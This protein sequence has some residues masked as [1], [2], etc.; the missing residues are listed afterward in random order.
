VVN[1]THILRQASR[2]L[3]VRPRRPRPT[4]NDYVLIFALAPRDK[5]APGED[6]FF[7]QSQVERF[8]PKG[9]YSD[10]GIATEIRIAHCDINS[11]FAQRQ[12]LRCI[13]SFEATDLHVRLSAPIQ[14]KEFLKRSREHARRYSNIQVSDFCSSRPGCILDSSTK[15][16]HEL[17]RANVKLPPGGG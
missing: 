10:A 17:L 6:V 11:V 14:L 5:A 9:H 16:K 2:K 4:S 3:F 8:V 1:D 13:F 15:L 12:Y 7:G